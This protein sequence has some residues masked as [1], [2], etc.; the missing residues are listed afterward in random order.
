MQKD[1]WLKKLGP[2][3]MYAGVAVGVSHLVNS[4]KAGALFGFTL[5]SLI[6][7]ANLIKLPFFEIGPRY[8]VATGKSLL[9]GYKQLGNWA[10]CLLILLT[11]STMFIIQAAVTVVTAGLLNKMLGLSLPGWQLS[12]IL[13]AVCGLIL[14]FNNFSLLDNLMKVIMIILSVAT[15]VAVIAS[16]TVNVEVKPEFLF[17]VD[18][19]KKEHLIFLVVLFGWMPGPLDITIWHS[20]WTLAKDSNKGPEETQNKQNKKE[21]L[22][23]ALFDFHVGYWGTALLAILFLSLGALIMYGSGTQFSKKGGEFAGQLISMYTK[24]LGNWSYAIILIAAFTTMFSTTLTALD[25]FGRLLGQASLMILALKKPR[26][27]PR[28]SAE[29]KFY[30][31]W[32][33]IVIIGSLVLLGGFIKSMGQMVKIATTISFLTT[34]IIAILNYVVMMRKDVPDEFKP[35]KKMQILSKISIAI[36]VV[37]SVIFL[38]IF[39]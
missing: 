37:F 39:F 38:I 6:V 11:L 36:F 16:F 24:C 1:K 35:G 27:S 28:P 20:I 2:G 30:I 4:T 33:S 12:L 31:L 26:P 25:G 3:L 23:T 9:Q 5:V 8:A 17:Q 10:F 29:K 21:A 15:L 18:L 14:A 7:I 34:P 13:L 22:K 32:I 19:F